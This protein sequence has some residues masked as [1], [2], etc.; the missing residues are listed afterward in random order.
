MPNHRKLALCGNVGVLILLAVDDDGFK[1]NGKLGGT[2]RS[3]GKNQ[4]GERFHGDSESNH[5]GRNFQELSGDLSGLVFIGKTDPNDFL[6][7][8][9]HLF[10]DPA[11]IFVA[12]AA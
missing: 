1:N 6:P 2:N 10:P 4:A 8:F 11:R 9:G 3:N 5:L 7:D 12:P